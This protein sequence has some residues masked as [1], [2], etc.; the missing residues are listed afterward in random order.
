MIDEFAG[1]LSNSGLELR[2]DLG[3]KSLTYQP[4]VTGVF[5]RINGQH[6][7]DP[8]IA[9]FGVVQL[10][11]SSPVFGVTFHAS[12]IK[13]RRKCCRVHSARGDVLISSHQVDR[14]S[15]DISLKHA[16]LF[17]HLCVVRMRAL[18]DLGIKEIE[19][20]QSAVS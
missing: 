13:T 18:L 16:Q 11:R 14:G 10:L 2:D 17:L 3:G 6:C 8:L 4:S 15:K 20:L 19:A 7:P 9:A 1:E 5:W 12:G